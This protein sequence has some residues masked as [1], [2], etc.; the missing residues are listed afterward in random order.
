[1]TIVDGGTVEEELRDS[2]NVTRSQNVVFVVPHDWAS[3]SYFLA[4]LIERVDE[5]ANTVQVLVIAADAE[6][7]AAVAAGAV[8]LSGDRAIGIVA[9]TSAAR[10]T[11]ILKSLPSQVVVGTPA[12]LL[13]LVRATTLKLGNVKAVAF[14]WADA[15]LEEVGTSEVLT[16]LMGDVPKDASRT[17][18]TTEVNPAV[19]D[20]IERYARRARRV[21]TGATADTTPIALEYVTAAETARIVTLRR[22][23]DELD[24]DNAAVYVRNDDSTA[25]VDGLLRSLGYAGEKA[26]VR[27]SR[28]GGSPA[29]VLLFDLPA[30]R[31]ELTEAMGAS[32]KRVIAMIQPRQLS[33]LRSLAGGGRVRPV[34]LQD[35]ARRARGRDERIRD[36]LRSM[37]SSGTTARTIFAIEPL[38]EEFDGVDIAAAAIELLE[39]ERAKPRATEGGSEK[40]DGASGNFTR[41]FFA[42]G[43]RDNVRVGEIVAV[44]GNDAQVPSTSLGKIDIRDT[45]TLVEVAPAMAQQVIDKLSGKTI[46]GRRVIV[47]PDNDPGER[48]ARSGGGDRPRGGPRGAGGDRPSRGGP[49]REGGAGRPSFGERRPRP[50]GARPRKPREDR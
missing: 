35:A 34:T 15:I 44:I 13:D 19:E 6:A 47:R 1:L 21:S 23:L 38:L 25:D 3:I 5:A 41:L 30:S 26:P 39:R 42:V 20:L 46:G 36:E 43:A 49:R 9:A 40:G 10:T 33:S 32:A 50:E 24:L 29:T 18:A 8:R 12:T 4:P 11:R 37:L 45:H 22:L 2:G 7:A 28:G 17:I 48:P 16:T 14:A 31:E 27:I